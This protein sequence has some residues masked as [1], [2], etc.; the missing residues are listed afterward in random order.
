MGH[1]FDMLTFDFLLKPPRPVTGLFFIYH[2]LRKEQFW[3]IIIRHLIY[4]HI[5]MIIEKLKCAK[6]RETTKRNYLSIWR[7]FNKFLGKLDQVP[8]NW[9]QRTILCI[10]HLVDIGLQSGTVCS[11]ILAI[12]SVLQDDDYQWND[13]QILLNTL[14][15]A[16]KVVNDTV[17]LHRPIK[18]PLLETILF[19]LSRIFGNQ[20]YLLIM[21]WALFALLYYG[22]FRIG[23]LTKG[24]HPVKAADVHISLKKNKML[25]ILWTSK[26]HGKSSR[27]Q[28]IK[29]EGISSPTGEQNHFCPFKLTQDYL[30]LRGGYSSV[31]EQFFIFR[32]GS[33]VRANVVRNILKRVITKL[34]LDKK[35]FDTHSF[36][37]ERSCDLLKLGYMIEQIKIIGRW[38]SNAVYR[39]LRL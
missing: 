8:G 1:S 37:A 30:T 17:C 7:H 14:T 27:P 26:M 2:I 18:K 24:D 16:C 13:N 12:K 5:Y 34:N 33:P 20:Y 32:D 10:A 36:R 35:L 25:F 39:Y 38:R 21:Y 3:L 15:R 9:E 22:L 23:E 4:H 31:Q 19:E 6:Y 11:Y 28:K 29:I